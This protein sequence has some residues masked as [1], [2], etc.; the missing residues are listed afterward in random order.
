MALSAI[1]VKSAK[2][3]DK[4]YKLFDERG[5]FLLVTPAGSKLWRLKYR[6]DGREK[7]LALGAFPEV[8]LADARTRRDEERTRLS[9]GIDP[10][11]QRKAVRADRVAAV[12]NSFQSVA[13]EWLEKHRSEVKPS[14]SSK[15][16]RRLE[17]YVFPLIGS[18]PIRDIQPPEVLG[19]LRRI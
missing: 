1:E 13:D 3:R 14:H 12:A 5:L 4:Q 2:P 8:S 15:N 6:F 19:A 18:T 17:L 7:L 10:S 11:A 16:A 9:S